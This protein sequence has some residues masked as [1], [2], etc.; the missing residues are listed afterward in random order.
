MKDTI[1]SALSFVFCF[2]LHM[3]SAIERVLLSIL[4]VPWL[5]REPHRCSFSPSLP[6]VYYSTKILSNRVVR[7]EPESR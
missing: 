2:V 6:I 5:S 3:F 7:I 1:S 4:V